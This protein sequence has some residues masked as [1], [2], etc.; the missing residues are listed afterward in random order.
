MSDVQR[1]KQEGVE[2]GYPEQP[3]IAE[4]DGAQS[5]ELGGKG[6]LAEGEQ[7]AEQKAD[8]DSEREI[9]G[10]EVGQHLPDDSDRTARR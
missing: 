6:Q 8:R 7:G 1:Q 10:Q 3:R 9:F 5:V 2:I 4:A